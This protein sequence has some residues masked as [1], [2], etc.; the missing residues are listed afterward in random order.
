MFKK[1]DYLKFKLSDTNS[2][3]IL[4]K[5]EQEIP[6]DH[7]PRSQATFS[8]SSITS[9]LFLYRRRTKQLHNQPASFDTRSTLINQIFGRG[10][11]ATSRTYERQ[12]PQI[13]QV[14]MFCRDKLPILTELFANVAKVFVNRGCKHCARNSVIEF[15]YQRQILVSRILM[16]ELDLNLDNGFNVDEFN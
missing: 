5:H 9:I 14:S 16:Y 11:F 13:S 3:I 8:S 7:V 15:P 4:Y 2:P 12:L 10:I 1:K 6:N